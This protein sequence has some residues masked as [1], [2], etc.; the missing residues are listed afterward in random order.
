MTLTT[1]RR[2]RARFLAVVAGVT[3]SLA[4]AACS[5]QSVGSAAGS[6]APAA[7]A[8]PSSSAAGGQ[9]A[10]ILPTGDPVAFSKDLVQKSLNASEGFTP[11]ST[12]P[13]AQKP[14]ATIAFVAGDL[15]NGGHNSTSKAV[16]EAATVMGW[17]VSVYDGKGNAQGNSDA[18]DRKSVV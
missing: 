2:P 9:F 7:G 3:L 4:M 15:S 11:P 8:S 5:S 16:T 1:A 18:I 14:G 10:A 13:K 17:K 12:G 6:S